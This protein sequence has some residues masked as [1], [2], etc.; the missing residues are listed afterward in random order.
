MLKSKYIKIILWILVVLWMSVI[1][2]FSAQQS[3]KSS[4]T[5]GQFIKSIA[6]VVKPDICQEDISEQEQFIESVQNVV[7]KCAHFT[8]Y[9]ILGSLLIIAINQYKLKNKYKMLLALIISAIYA[10]TDEFHQLFV[11]GRSGNIRD[12]CID[13]SGALI[14]ILI[15]SLIIFIVHNVHNKKLEVK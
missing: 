7:R 15:L 2:M 13:I 14:G 11:M 9:F 1:F 12:V 5:S 10:M 3:D 4:D 8:E 6:C